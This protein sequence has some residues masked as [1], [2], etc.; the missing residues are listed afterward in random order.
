M[1]RSSS[2]FLAVDPSTRK[3][4]GAFPER[5]APAD[6]PS[7]VERRDYRSHHTL[8][9]TLVPPLAVTADCQLALLTICSSLG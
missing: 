8:S 7:G 3:E 5:K 9:N 1:P 2:F 6:L 4:A